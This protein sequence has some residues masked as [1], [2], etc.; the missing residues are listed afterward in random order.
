[1]LAFVLMHGGFEVSQPDAVT[2]MIPE[3]ARARALQ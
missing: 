3:A 2:N 1:V